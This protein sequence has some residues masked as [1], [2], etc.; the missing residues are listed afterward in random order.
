M[1]FSLVAWSEEQDTGGT[2]TEMLALKDQHVTTKGNDVLVPAFAPN[3]I[4]LFA[5][6]AGISR[7]QFSTPSLR[8]RSLIDISPL[9]IAAKPQSN[10]RVVNF[11]ERPVPLTAGEGARFLVAETASGAER[12][13]GLAWLQGEREEAPAGDIETIRCT[14]NTTLT[15]YEWSLCELELSQQL[16]AG[17]YAIV[18]MAAYSAGAI[19]ARLVI[20]GSAF[21]PGAIA[22]DSEGKFSTELSRFGRLGKWGEF[23]H[24]YPPQIEFLSTSADTA[25]TVYLDVVKVE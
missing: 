3:L 15:P 21:R 4:A 23:E 18:G 6:G 20:P 19:A 12:E 17:R 10:P 2:L 14:A 24:V 11:S 13:F 9:N 25:E 7:A 8:E 5:L 1:A 16:R 22:L